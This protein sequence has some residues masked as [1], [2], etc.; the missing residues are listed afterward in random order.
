VRGAAV[1]QL[2]GI[3]QQQF[4]RPGRHKVTDVKSLAASLAFSLTV[5]LAAC[6]VDS[7]QAGPADMA[8]KVRPDLWT[9]SGCVQG[10]VQDENGGP[11]APM[12][13]ILGCSSEL[14]LTK[15]ASLD[16]SFKICGLHLR[17]I[18]VKTEPDLT[19]NPRRAASMCPIV[20]TSDGQD[21]DIS[22]LTVPLLGDGVN[23]SG[24]MDTPQTLA[25]GDG[26]SV[27]LLQ[28]DYLRP[29]GFTGDN[30]AARAVP[31]GKHCPLTIPDGGSELAV[32]AISPFAATMRPPGDGG[33]QSVFAFQATLATAPNA[34]V[35]FWAIS[36]LDGTLLGPAI[37]HGDGT[38]VST[39]PGQG[40]SEL[41]WMVI[42]SKSP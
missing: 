19:V 21:I 14:C 40:L 3:P 22:K 35:H 41:S 11:V 31:K 18:V 33:V 29:L 10:T 27:T 15:P 20:L 37:G 30:L 4:A 7:K 28:K 24:A 5:S 8:V 6:S 12:T 32:Y 34:E 26:L 1:A 39:D 42:S 23:L 9:P 16:G 25:L 38:T 2:L 36:D 13:S 17:K